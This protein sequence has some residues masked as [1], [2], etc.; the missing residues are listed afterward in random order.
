MGFSGVNKVYRY[1][2]QGP[3]DNTGNLGWRFGTH[4]HSCCYGTF[5]STS[6]LT[7][8]GGLSVRSGGQ[9]DVFFR[10]C[11]SARKPEAKP[12]DDGV[13]IKLQRT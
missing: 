5:T 6:R 9:P 12:R 10:R 1:S 8:G 4:A 2:L 13:E 3:E 11:G 7:T